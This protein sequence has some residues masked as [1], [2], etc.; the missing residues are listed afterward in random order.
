METKDKGMESMKEI[1]PNKV[2]REMEIELRT[3]MR[4][5]DIRPTPKTW[6]GKLKALGPT[7]ILAGAIVGSGELIATTLLGAKI[8]FIMLWAIIFS[9]LAKIMI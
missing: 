4:R 5:E 2:L 7:F 8:G 1:A 9:C 6:T 3:E